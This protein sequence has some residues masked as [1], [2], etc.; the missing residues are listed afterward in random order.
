VTNMMRSVLSEGTGAGARGLGFTL[1]G[2]GKTGTTND[3]RD[4]WFAGYTPDLLCVVWVGFDDNTPINLPGSR[5]ALPIWLDFMKN[6]LAGQK[7]HAFTVPASNVVFEEI[8]K[9]TGLLAGPS[10]P[11]VFN[12]AFIAGTEP[13][14]RCE[15]H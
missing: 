15:Q 13:H 3:L 7:D 14:E 10:C 11:K 4:A 2:A 9:E 6:A 5:A 8:D 12:E 1:D